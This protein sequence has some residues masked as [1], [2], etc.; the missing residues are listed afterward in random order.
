MIAASALDSDVE[1]FRHAPPLRSAHPAARA[2]RRLSGG[3]GRPDPALD[4][5][6]HPQGAMDADRLPR[7]RLDRLLVQRPPPRRAAA[8]DAVQPAGGAARERL[9]DPR[10]RRQRR[11]SARR[12]DARGQRPRVDAARSAARRARGRRAAADGDGGDRRRRLHLRRR[13]DAA[14]RQPRRRAA[15][16][17]ARR[18]AARA[19]RRRAGAGRVPGGPFAAHRRRRVSR[20]VGTLGS[21][22]HHLPPG[23]PPASTAGARRRQPA[24]ARRGAPGLAAP[25]PRD[26]PRDQQLA[27]ADQVDRRQPRVDARARDHARRLARGHAARPGG[28]RGAVGFAQP[29]HHRLR[30]PRQTARAAPSTR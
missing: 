28:D 30:A 4:R 5:R 2:R 20:R 10:A 26:R 16:R 25:D 27:R 15:A 1:P 3:G 12:G 17:P 19:H 13:A 23:R 24:A 9:L 11:R 29:L 7:R 18:A 22:P 21:A 14:P 6:L 8:A